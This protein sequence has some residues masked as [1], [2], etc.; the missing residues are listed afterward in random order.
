MKKVLY[1][2]IGIIIGASIGIG[3]TSYAAVKQFILTQFDRPVVVNGVVY[4]DASNPILNYNGKTY[5]PLAKIGELTGVNYVWNAEKRQVEI[6]SITSASASNGSQNYVFQDGR[7]T[8]IDAALAEEEAIKKFTEENQFETVKKAGLVKED[9][10]TVLYLINNVGNSKRFVSEDDINYVSAKIN[11]EPLPP[12]IAEGWISEK[13][14]FM[15]IQGYDYITDVPT[16]K[17]KDVKTKKFNEITYYSIDDLIKI[18][19]I[20]TK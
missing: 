4:K 6:G 8:T 11:K 7:L 16:D 14:L 9:G 3:T 13:M 10:T 2:A 15:N 17:L 18:G 1:I 12:S 20:K 5:I 19:L